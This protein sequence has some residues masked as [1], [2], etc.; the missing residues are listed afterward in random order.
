MPTVEIVV[1]TPKGHSANEIAKQIAGLDYETRIPVGDKVIRSR[2]LSGEPVGEGAVRVLVE[3][4][5]D[6]EG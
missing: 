3:V 6:G 1:P 5:L 4:A 2:A